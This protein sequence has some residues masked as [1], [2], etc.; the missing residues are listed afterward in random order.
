MNSKIMV[1]TFFGLT[2]SF[3][4]DPSELE[5]SFFNIRLAANPDYYL[6]ADIDAAL[7]LEHKNN[8]WFDDRKTYFTFNRAT[9]NTI[10]IQEAGFD[11]KKL[12]NRML[13]T[14]INSDIMFGNVASNFDVMISPVDNTEQAYWEGNE[15]FDEITFQTITG[16][17]KTRYLGFTEHEELYVYSREFHNELRDKQ[18]CIFKLGDRFLTANRATVRAPNC[19]NGCENDTLGLSL[20]PKYAKEKDLRT[21]LTKSSF[22]LEKVDDKIRF[23]SRT[24]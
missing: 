24:V 20:P 17:S 21:F 1:S 9:N 8:A 4:C 10:E 15:N 13:T 18:A 7:I 12:A 3:M 16:D 6:I 5:G 11:F 23:S 14:D 22:I 2:A 19:I